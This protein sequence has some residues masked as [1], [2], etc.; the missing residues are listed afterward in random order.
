LKLSFSSVVERVEVPIFSTT[1]P[2]ALF[3]IKAHSYKFAPAAKLKATV[4]IKVSPAPETS[5][6]SFAFVGR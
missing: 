1:F 3:P 2:A 6:I 5:Y 4:Q